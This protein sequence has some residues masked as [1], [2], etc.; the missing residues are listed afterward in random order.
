MHACIHTY[1]HKLAYKPI[2]ECSCYPLTVYETCTINSQIA[3]L[4]LQYA[5]SRAYIYKLSFTFAQVYSAWSRAH[6]YKLPSYYC[7]SIQYAWSKAQ[8]Y[9]FI[10]FS[11]RAYHTKKVIMQINIIIRKRFGQH[12]IQQY[13][14]DGL[15]VT[16]TS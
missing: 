10:Y 4:C 9:K 7:T 16:I 3:I 13:N 6:I 2:H 11:F 15:P 12:D 8:I 1:I 14:S 5:W